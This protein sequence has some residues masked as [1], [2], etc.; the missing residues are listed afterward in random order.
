VNCESFQSII[1]YVLVD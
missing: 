1:L